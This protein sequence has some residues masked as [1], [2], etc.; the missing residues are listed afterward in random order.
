MNDMYTKI[1]YIYVHVFRVKN[2]GCLYHILV[3]FSFYSDK[4]VFDHGLISTPFNY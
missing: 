2:I 4:G 1:Y 3:K